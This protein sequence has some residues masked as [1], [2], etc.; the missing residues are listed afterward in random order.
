MYRRTWAPIVLG[1]FLAGCDPSPSTDAAETRI[2]AT[3]TM[4]PTNTGAGS[5]AEP[6]VDLPAE[7]VNSEAAR[8]ALCEP[9]AACTPD[10][11]PLASMVAVVMSVRPRNSDPG[12]AHG[13]ELLLPWR[14]RPGAPMSY[15]PRCFTLPLANHDFR[16]T[17]RGVADPSRIWDRPITGPLVLR[18]RFL[19]GTPARHTEVLEHARAWCD[20]AALEFAQS[21]AYDAQIRVSFAPGRGNWSY[22]GTDAVRPDI[23]FAQASMNLVDTD[24]GTVLHEFGHALG[25]EHEHQHPA[26]P[27]LLNRQ[28]ILT[29][30]TQPPNSWSVEQVDRNI[31]DRF[32]PAAVAVTPFD[33]ASIMTYEIATSWLLDGPALPRNV[34]LSTGDIALVC[35]LY[36]AR[37]A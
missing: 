31:L 29:E 4:T 22:V 25:L 9:T 26:T 10:A 6:N 21:D 1:A 5:T 37:L 27:L 2:E 35:A 16:A 13:G 33:P 11:R 30:M 18:V 23:G 20:H 14:F 17:A 7:P 34:C 15:P 28:Q 36:G 12:V 19:D 3:T 24:Q 8:T 32:A